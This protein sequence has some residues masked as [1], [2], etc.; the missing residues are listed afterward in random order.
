MIE[1]LQ[2]KNIAL[3]EQVAIDFGEGLHVL[4]GETGAGKSIVVDAVNLAL[5]GRADRDL[6][7][8][9]TEKASVEAVFRADGNEAVDAWLRGHEIEAEAGEVIL[10]REIGVNGRNVCRV[11]GAVVPVSALKELSALLMDVHGQHE[12]QFLMDPAFH[13]RFLDD[14]GDDAHQA[15]RAEVAKASEDFLACHRR[16]ARLVRENEQKAFRM[17]QLTASLDELRK[18]DLKPGEEE[19]LTRERE[20]GR[21]FGKIIGALQA[22]YG[23]LSGGESDPL[24]AVKSALHALQ[25]IEGLGDDY[26]ALS[27]RAASAYYELEEVS[28]DLANLIEKSEF[29]PA[30]AEWVETRLDLIRRLE[31]KYGATVEEVL[32]E[33]ERLEEEFDRLSGMDRDLAS[34]AKEDKALLARYRQE[35]RRLTESRTALARDFERRMGEQLRD[36]GMEKTVFQVAFAEHPGGKLPMPR[37]EGDDEVEFMISPNPG[38]PLKPLAKIASGGEL[39]RLMLALKSLE[40]ERGGVGC[41]VF[42]EIDTGISGRMAQVVGEKM[43]AISRRRQVICVT[44]LPQ[45][46]ALA[47]HEYLVRK[48]VDG[49]RTF[50]RVREVTGEERVEEVA[51]M[52]GGADGSSGSA[53][54]HAAQMLESAE[55]YRKAQKRK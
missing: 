19:A 30:R 48:E 53:K 46:A 39:S 36:L 27:T 10:Q 31:R 23:M 29:N 41:M 18:A 52:L 6:I 22:A 8:T 32:A 24:S 25:E 20:Q 15:L 50:T 40:A 49:D 28:Y 16:Y 43:A 42:D 2:I 11:C 33:K 9:G 12:H 14:A 1:S 38:E 5:G 7:R 17:E 55:A 35:A 4:T 21:H 3:A 37:A 34:L 26:K 13:L 47:D 54:A 45:I 44:H 51:R